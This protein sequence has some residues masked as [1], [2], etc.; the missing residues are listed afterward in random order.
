MLV[1][2]ID[3]PYAAPLT[4]IETHLEIA[5]LP[6]IRDNQ[7]QRV[8]AV[9]RAERAGPPARRVVI[10]GDFNQGTFGHEAEL[11][12]AGLRRAVDPPTAVADRLDQIWIDNDLLLLAT[13]ELP[14]MGITDH[15]VAARATIQ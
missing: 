12:D 11:M 7:L 9:V 10:L 3:R 13:D 15:A 2:R 6:E 14:T 8:L 1:T 5:E 4:V